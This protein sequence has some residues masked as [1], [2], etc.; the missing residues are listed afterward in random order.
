MIARRRHVLARPLRGAARGAQG[1]ARL[2][3]QVIDAR[4]A[5][6]LAYSIAERDD[7]WSWRVYD[8]DGEVIASGAAAN[9]AEAQGAVHDIYELA[10]GA[11]S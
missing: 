5:R 1:R 9:K 4:S 7:A 11:L 3:A 8:T 10:G 6:P 2:G